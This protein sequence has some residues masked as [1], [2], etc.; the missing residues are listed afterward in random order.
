MNIRFLRT[1]IMCWAAAG[2]GVPE[3]AR[4]SGAPIV[5][6]AS[7]SKLTLS[8]TRVERYEGNFAYVRL[9]ADY[10]GKGG[11]RKGTITICGVPQSVPPRATAILYGAQLV[12]FRIEGLPDFMVKEL[13]QAAVGRLLQGVELEQ[14]ALMGPALL[15]E[16]LFPRNARGLLRVWPRVEVRRI[17]AVLLYIDSDPIMATVPG[18]ELQY[19]VNTDWDLFFHQK[20]YNHFLRVGRSWFEA[21]SVEGPWIPLRGE[22]PKD[23]GNIPETH[24]RAHIRGSVAKPQKAEPLEI[25]VAT[26]PTELVV[27]S[28]EPKLVPIPETPYSYAENTASDLFFHKDGGVVLLASGR[29]FAAR[30]L[31]GPWA[32]VG[33]EAPLELANIPKTHPKAHVRAALPGT[34]EA[35]T[36]VEAANTAVRA[37]VRR[38]LALEVKLLGPPELVP[39][40]GELA[41]VKNTAEDMLAVAGRYYCCRNGVWFAANEAVGPWAVAREVPGAV[42]TLPPSSPLYHLRFVQVLAYSPTT[43]TF[44]YTSGYVGSF[45]DGETVVYG[46]G[47]AEP[48]YVAAGVYYGLPPL[49][50]LGRRLDPNDARFLEL[51]PRVGPFAGTDRDVGKAAAGEAVGLWPRWGRIGYGAGARDLAFSIVRPMEWGVG[52]LDRGRWQVPL[53]DAAATA[54]K[55]LPPPQKEAPPE[56][57][58][59]KR[60][61]ALFLGTNDKVYKLDGGKWWALAKPGSAQWNDIG[62]PPR[63]VELQAALVAQMQPRPRL[64][65]SD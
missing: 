2:L 5:I 57:Q 26:E 56:P 19:V 51:P 23:F 8:V 41:Y 28:G 45:V 52:C 34:E 17:P 24:P 42:Q 55:P 63:D 62:A 59:F 46:T 36:A 32:G 21:Y 64:K 31:D 11:Q 10:S 15:P 9:E 3:A 49:L 33:A 37:T 20:A 25:V 44:G 50:G 16:P 13:R 53:A 29:W 27:L 18:T 1:S 38:D 58:P 65:T 7:G 39:V 48:G 4:S 47:F 35:R 12:D 40:Q 61:P 60:P 14:E 43:V 30:S 22:L 6:E 54:P